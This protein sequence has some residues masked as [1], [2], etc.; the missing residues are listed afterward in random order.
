[1]SATF[2]LICSPEEQKCILFLGDCMIKCRFYSK[3]HR[4]HTVKGLWMYVVIY[5]CSY[6]EYCDLMKLSGNEDENLV[7]LV[8]L[9]VQ[10]KSTHLGT[11][12]PLAAGL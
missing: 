2:S 7:K 11:P 8:S 3:V 4:A 10:G 5:V 9:G 12:V 6:E 1:M